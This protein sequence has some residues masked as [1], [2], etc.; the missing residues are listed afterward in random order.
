[1]KAKDLRE[2]TSEELN[3]LEK[4]LKQKLFNL[5]FQKVMGQLQNPMKVKEV[6]K[7]IARVKTILNERGE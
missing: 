5:N 4:E 7:D 2:K 6:K 1:M 3:N